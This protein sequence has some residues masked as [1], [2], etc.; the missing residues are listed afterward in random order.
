MK[1]RNHSW[2]ASALPHSEGNA[3]K[4]QCGEIALCPSQRRRDAALVIADPFLAHERAL[5]AKLMVEHRLPSISA[6]H[7][8]AV[9]GG[10]VAYVTSYYD[11]FRRCAR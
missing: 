2:V 6:Y 4:P 10:L 3:Y 8:C 11:I 7:E 9:A 1:A 5:L